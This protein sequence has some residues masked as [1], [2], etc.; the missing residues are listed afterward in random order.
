MSRKLFS[1]PTTFRV[2]LRNVSPS[3]HT[4]SL[5]HKQAVQAKKKTK[6]NNKQQQQKKNQ[7]LIT[8]C[9]VAFA[10]GRYNTRSDWLIVTGL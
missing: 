7:A 5:A 6:T 9:Y 1:G 10:C 2:S 3:G 8:I 4:R